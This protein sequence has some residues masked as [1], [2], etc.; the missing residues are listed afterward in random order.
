MQGAH[1]E[2]LAL[3]IFPDDMLPLREALH[4]LAAEAP[5]LS[6]DLRDLDDTGRA[7]AIVEFYWQ[8]MLPALASGRLIAHGV[9]VEQDGQAADH[10]SE[11][12][13]PEAWRSDGNASSALRVRSPGLGALF[14][15]REPRHEVGT[16]S[17]RGIEYVPLFRPAELMAWATGGAVAERLPLP[18]VD[19]EEARALLAV[20]K[21][22][23]PNDPAMSEREILDW[24]RTRYS[25]KCTG[26]QLRKLMAVWPNRTRGP[27]PGQARAATHRNPT[28]TPPETARKSR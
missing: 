12:I 9:V 3:A 28:E 25:G 8:G 14:D 5:S 16:V 10:R 7:L 20:L 18:P 22:R 4:L 21:R 26:P 11:P 24:V 23:R 13:P 1:A 15:S 6:A 19:G 2:A 27:R 17:L